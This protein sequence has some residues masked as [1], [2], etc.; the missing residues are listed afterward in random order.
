M[1]FRF[2]SR[3]QFLFTATNQHGVHSPFVYNFVT[4]GLYIKINSYIEFNQIDIPNNLTK[5]QEKILKKTIKYFNPKSILMLDNYKSKALNNDFNLIYFK[6]LNF[7]DFEKI[8]KNHPN[9]FFVLN[10]INV[11]KNSLNNWKKIISSS[12]A[13]VTIDLF[14]FGL[15]FFR[16]G[17]RKEHFKIRV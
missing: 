5:K 16:N 8:S 10:N 14:Y 6:Y 12:K 2:I 4:K 17:Q 13:I 3:I 11:N 9:S 1:F 15:V 7:N